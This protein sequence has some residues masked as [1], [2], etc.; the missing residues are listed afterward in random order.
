MAP[1][2]SFLLR[3]DPK[4]LDAV[5]RWADD[6]L[7]SVNGQMEFIL[8]RALKDAGRTIAKDEPKEAKSN[9]KKK[10]K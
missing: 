10:K 6:D 7:R 5:R 9:S 8:R 3:L 1:R 4:V 2:D